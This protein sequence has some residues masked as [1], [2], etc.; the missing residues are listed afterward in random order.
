MP[1]SRDI[2]VKIPLPQA[3][4]NEFWLRYCERS[5]QQHIFL[6]LPGN[7]LQISAVCFRHIHLHQIIIHY[8]L[9]KSAKPDIP[10]F[11][12][13]IVLLIHF[14]T[15]PVC[16]YFFCVS[17]FFMSRIS[18]AISTSDFS[19]GGSTIFRM[20]ANSAA[21]TIPEPPKINVIACGICARTAEFAPSP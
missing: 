11:A 3:I 12:L 17:F 8:N 4:W 10:S 9:N 19:S 7:S 21:G 18:S 6:S 5:E 16:R 2:Q 20:I 15:L 14:R 1:K 13:F